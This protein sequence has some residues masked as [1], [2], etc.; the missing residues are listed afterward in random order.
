[1]YGRMTWVPSAAIPRPPTKAHTSDAA[2]DLCAAETAIVGPGKPTVIGTGVRLAL[3]G[4]WFAMI[5]SRSGMASKGFFV[6]NAPGIIDSGYR[7]EIKIILG[8]LADEMYV[9]PGD[10]IAQLLFARSLDL[11]LVG[12]TPQEWE[13]EG[14]DNTDRGRNGLGSTGLTLIQGG[15]AA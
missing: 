7:G 14:L 2:Y 8:S 13:D 10:R 9:A 4:G 12:L 1:M 5:C 15:D 6:V 11:K 3:P